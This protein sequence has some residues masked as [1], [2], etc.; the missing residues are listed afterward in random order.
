[1]AML[2]S[3]MHAEYTPGNIGH[4]GLSL[5]A[6]AHFTSPIRRYP[7]LLVH[8]AIRHVLQNGKAGGYQYDAPAMDRLGKICS[9]HERRAEEATREVEAWLKC[10]FMQDKVG[11]TYGGVITGVTNFGAFVQIP[12]M[13]IDGLVHVTSLANDYYKYDAGAQ[14]LVGERSGRRYKLGDRLNVTVGRVDLDTRRIDFSLAEV[15]AEG[16]RRKSTTRR[17]GGKPG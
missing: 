15:P 7:D 9:A 12:E 3:L 2:R 17:K 11:N 8:R 13:Q 5:D 16:T 4:F 6:Y 14:A 10:Q 1:M